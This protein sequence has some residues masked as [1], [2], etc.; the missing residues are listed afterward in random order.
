MKQAVSKNRLLSSKLAAILVLLIGQ[1][2]NAALEIN[3]PLDRVIAVVNDQVITAL[4]LD[5]E[6]G[7]IKQQLRQQNNRLPDDA[8]L[9]KQL[10]ERLILRDIQ[11]QMAKRGSIRVDDETL[12]KTLEN[13]AAQNRL[14]L[15][16]F[17][18]TLAREGLEYEAFRENMRDEIIISR[19][20]QREVNNRIVITQQ[21]IDTF[22]S[23]QALRNGLNKEYHLGHILIALPEAANAAQIAAA[24]TKAEKIVADLRAGAEFYQTAASVSDG[25]QALEGGDL[26][27]RGAAALPTLF[28]DWVIANKEN[29]ISDALRSPSGF[30]IIKLLGQR[31]SENKHMVT[32]NHVRHILIRP[33][34][35]DDGEKARAKIIKIRERILAG[36]DFAVLAK[37]ESKDPGSAVEGGELGWVSPGE[38]VPEFDAAMNELK[39]EEI[40]KPIRTQY[41]WHLLQVLER[42]DQDITDKVQRKN[43][44]EVIRARKTDPAMQEW[45]RRI[46]DEAF[47]ENRL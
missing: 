8:V 16:E 42:R 27:W 14:S 12:N 30:H 44:Q 1:T 36:E 9:K 38:M 2:A 45:I 29:S 33:E 34:S 37:A 15:A 25:Q 26:G 35:Q 5:K 46:R 10:L 39:L 23:N 6:M 3:D 7:L 17:R 41:G 18:E 40:S 32:Q 24:R 20:Q 47:V 31:T 19:L 13:I 43:A 4:E 21:E 11:L 22:I 28:S